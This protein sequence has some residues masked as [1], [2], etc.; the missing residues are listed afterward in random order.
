M[1]TVLLALCIVALM[2]AAGIHAELQQFTAT[3]FA[4]MRCSTDREDQAITTWY[5]NLSCFYA[6][7]GSNLCLY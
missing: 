6:P 3:E 7:A 4:R 2:A 1:K 5:L